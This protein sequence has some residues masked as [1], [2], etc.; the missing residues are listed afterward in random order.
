V[1]AEDEARRLEAERGWAIARDGSGFR[2]V[3]AS[4]E[5]LEIVEI[6]TIRLLVEAGVLVVCAGGGGIPVTVAGQ[7]LRGVEAVIDKDLAAALLAAE[8]SADV[9]LLLTDVPAVEQGF[10][11]GRATPIERATPEEL[12]AITFAPGSMAPKID[13]SCRFVERTGRRA[14]IGGLED[15]AALLAGETGTQVERSGRPVAA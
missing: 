9:L 13:A 15:A 12:R 7:G 4:P 10:G 14:A 1:Y 6:E 3:V 8:L 5:P 11:T 2:R